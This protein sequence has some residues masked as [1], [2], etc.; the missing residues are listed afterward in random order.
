MFNTSANGWGEPDARAQGVRE[1]NRKLDFRK[2]VTYGVDRQR[3][4][5]SLVKGP[6]TAPYPGGLLTS[7]SY[8]DPASTV[9][10]PFSADSSTMTCWP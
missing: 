9:F 10:Y 6:F 3:L 4:G 5:D 2:A 8:Y 7:T 1:L